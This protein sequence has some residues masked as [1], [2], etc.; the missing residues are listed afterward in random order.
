MGGERAGNGDRHAAEGA[1]GTAGYQDGI[2]G[3][4]RGTEFSG[5]RQCGRERGILCACSRE[6][7]SSDKS[8]KGEKG[9][10]VSACRHGRFSPLIMAAPKGVRGDPAAM[11]QGALGMLNV[12]FILPNWEKRTLFV[13]A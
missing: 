10:G 13:S 11:G 1:V 2:G 7:P 8:G 4:Q 12:S 5:W 9:D 6:S 3:D